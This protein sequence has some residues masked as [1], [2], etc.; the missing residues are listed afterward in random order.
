MTK[1][2]EVEGTNQG[3]RCAEGPFYAGSI[4]YQQPA[5]LAVMWIIGGL[6]SLV[7]CA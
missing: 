6:V 3:E 7:G 5:G 4:A 1:V 2:D